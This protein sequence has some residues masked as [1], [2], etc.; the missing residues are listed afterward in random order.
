MKNCKLNTKLLFIK[1]VQKNYLMK[2]CFKFWFILLT[3]FSCKNE[4]K[5]NT[6]LSELKNRPVKFS[7]QLRGVFNQPIDFVEAAEKSI[8]AVVHVK[9]TSVVSDDFSYLD[10]F[11][12][13]NKSPQNRIGTGSGVIVSPDGFIITNNHV[14]EDATKI[15]V[16]TNENIRYEAKL[17]GT[18][19]YTDIAVLKIETKKL[20]PYLYFADSDNTKIGEW[21]L[22][23]GNPF[24]LNS[25][26]TAGIISAKSRDLN[27]LDRR[28]QSFIQTDAA[29]NQGNSG[30]ALVNLNGELIGINTAITTISGGFEGYSFAVPSNIARKV[31]EDIIE[32]GTNQKGMLGVQGFAISPEFEKFIKENKIQQ[33]EGFYVSKVLENMGAFNAGI[34]EGDILIS[35]DDIK[36]KKFSDLTGYLESKRPGD[37]VRLGFFRNDIKKYLNVKLE[38]TKTVEFLNMTLSNLTNKEKEDLK[39]DSGLRILDSG[40]LLEGQIENNS[41]LIDINGNII[42]AVDQI[43]QMDPNRVRWITYINPSGEKIRLRF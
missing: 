30:G 29:V 26:V 40:E 1:F 37:R 15:E 42:D 13:R 8:N 2:T 31:F 3:F 21:V 17:V 10:Y 24:N 23:I 34:K 35:V 39:I 22:A 33:S 5:T 20:L 27:K 16:T 6:V 14:I 32:F 11:Y 19:P 28:N 18:D 9:N 36:I 43:L 25:T 38:K 12:G 41:I 4:I 7:P